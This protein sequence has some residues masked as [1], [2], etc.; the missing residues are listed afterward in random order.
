VVVVITVIEVVVVVVVVV[1]IKQNIKTNCDLQI[2]APLISFY[3]FNP[4]DLFYLIQ[5]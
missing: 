2:A 4:F 3:C 5:Y 1:H